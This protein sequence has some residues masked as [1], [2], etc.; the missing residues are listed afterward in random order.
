MVM[1]S[2]ASH[3]WT[4]VLCILFLAGA[5]TAWAH[6]D[7]SGCTKPGVTIVFTTFRADGVTEVASSDTVIPCETIIYQATLSKPV[8]LVGTTD[9]VC[10]FQSG[11]I[12]IVTP[13]GVSH[14][15][16]PVGGIP[17]VGGT[18]GVICDPTVK[19]VPTQKV[20]YVVNPANEVMGQL[21][22]TVNYGITRGGICTSDC[23]TEHAAATDLTNKVSATLASTA[24]VQPCPA[25]TQC[26]QE[27]CDA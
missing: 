8:E 15:V 26:I 14:P 25:P 6:R 4:G 13:D 12:F 21:A 5:E 20:T 19:S 22:A 24:T 3:W 11:N 1:T 27:M 23:G 9:T 7:P 16:T 18:D 10:A 2:A 17:C